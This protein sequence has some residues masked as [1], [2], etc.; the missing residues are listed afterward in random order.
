MSVGYGHSLNSCNLNSIYS[1]APVA[2]QWWRCKE[3]DLHCA[4]YCHV[5]WTPSHRRMRCSARG[6]PRTRMQSALRRK[7]V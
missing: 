1:A 6:L 7:K 4:S 3:T 5:S 2:L